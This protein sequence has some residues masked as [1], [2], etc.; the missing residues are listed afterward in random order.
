MELISLGFGKTLWTSFHPEYLKD[1][2]KCS[3]NQTW[4]HFPQLPFM[5]WQFKN[6]TKI[7]EGFFVSAFVPKLPDLNTNTEFV[8]LS[9]TVD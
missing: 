3:W 2:F 6:R 8:H 4:L 7:P 1:G 5:P 9:V